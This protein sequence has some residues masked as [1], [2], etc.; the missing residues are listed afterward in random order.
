[1]TFE[2]SDYNKGVARL[3]DLPVKRLL[4]ILKQ[5]LPVIPE[6]TL[7]GITDLHLP[8]HKVAV[9]VSDPDLIDCMK[10]QFAEGVELRDGFVVAWVNKNLLDDYLKAAEKAFQ[11]R[12]AS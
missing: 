2:N 11:K 7:L 9:A 6:K 5:S 10:N 1:M 12:K 4:R 8:D 3:S